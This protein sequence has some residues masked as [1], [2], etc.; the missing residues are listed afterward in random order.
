MNDRKNLKSLTFPRVNIV[1]RETTF[2]VFGDASFNGFGATCYAVNKGRQPLLMMAR[3]RVA[4][5]KSQTIPRLELKAATLVTEIANLL[6]NTFKIEKEKIICWSD[7]QIVLW[8]LQMK[9]E[10]LIP[11][12]ANRVQRIV[13]TKVQFLYVRTD[14]NPGDLTSRGT[15]VAELKERLSKKK[16]N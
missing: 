1:N 14:E 2:H 6:V 16:I 8:W 10:T 4:P 13:D 15:S 7:S 12:V 11:F 3:S 9:P 5:M